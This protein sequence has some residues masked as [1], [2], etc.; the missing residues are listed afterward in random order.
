MPSHNL[1]TGGRGLC[2]WSCWDD[3]RLSDRSARKSVAGYAGLE[4]SR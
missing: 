3:L 4:V 1:E 2:L